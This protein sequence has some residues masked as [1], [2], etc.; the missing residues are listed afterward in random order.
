MLN[1]IEHNSS[2]LLQLYMAFAIDLKNFAAT[3]THCFMIVLFFAQC[4]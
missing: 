2:A 1:K 3:V 4:F